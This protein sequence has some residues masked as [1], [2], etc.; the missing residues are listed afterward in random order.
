MTIA[1]STGGGNRDP[2]PGV[3]LEPESQMCMRILLVL[4]ATALA[5]AGPKRV[6]YVTYSAGYRHDSIP[7][8]EE[9]LRQI[10][11][12]SG[13]LEVVATQDLSLISSSGLRDFDAVFF[14]TSGELPVTDSQKQDLLSFVRSGKGFGGVH[15]ATDTFY[16]WPAYRDLIGARFNGHPWVQSVRIEAED[17]DHPAIRRLTPSFSVFD[18]I[19]QFSEFSRDRVRVLLT[20][21]TTSVDL[22]VPGTNRGTEDFPLAWCQKY[23]EGRVFYTALGH[24]ESTWRDQTVQEMLLQALLWLTGQVDGDA[25]PRPDVQPALIPNAIG[26]SASLSPRM[27]VS[28]DSLISIFGNN[29]TSGSMVAADPRITEHKLA[30]TT[31]RLNGAPIPLLF[32]SP[33]QINAFVPQDLD[34]GGL[35]N[36]DIAVAGGGSVGAAL[37]TSQ[38]TPGIFTLTANANYVTLWGTGLGPVTRIGDLDITQIQPS[39]NIAGISA[40][41]TY[42]GLSPGT[43]GLYQVNVEMPPNL[44]SPALLEFSF[45]GAHFLAWVH[46]PQ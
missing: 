33:G 17:P 36:L 26:N 12:N 11:A 31:V 38:T 37:Q 19:Y 43:P 39:V 32:A 20:L 14:F 24:F 8:S 5:S 15:S 35:W 16:T 28:P 46:P 18:E 7:A 42:S 34:P 4:F 23:G 27:T 2:W 13:R 44:P 10:G 29:L 1:Q 9:V 3:T 22:S 41:V 30:G 6:L 45:A 40:H 21:D 25:T